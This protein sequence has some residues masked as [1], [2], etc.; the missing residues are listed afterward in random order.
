MNNR[1]LLL[2]AGLL[3]LQI[4]AAQ[5]SDLIQLKDLEPCSAAVSRGAPFKYPDACKDESTP[6]HMVTVDLLVTEDRV[7]DEFLLVE[8]PYG[9]IRSTGLIIQI[10]YTVG[11]L[12]KAQWFPLGSMRGVVVMPDTIHLPVRDWVNSGLKVGSFVRVVV[13]QREK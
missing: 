13:I 5:A 3:A 4:T 11:V 9:E 10:F 1:I 12:G 2:S 6:L 7:N 8:M